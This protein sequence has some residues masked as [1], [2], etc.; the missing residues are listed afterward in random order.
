MIVALVG[1]SALVLTAGLALRGLLQDPLVAA[2]HAGGPS[3][4]RR[5]VRA[6]ASSS[7]P[8]TSAVAPA[9]LGAI[10]R[11]ADVLDR[12]RR[13]IAAEE[14]VARELACAGGWV[15]ER[16]VLVGTRRVPFVLLGPGGVFTLCATDGAWTLYDLEVLSRVGDELRDRLPG[17]RGRVEAVVC[18]AFDQAEP[19]AWYGGADSGR[20]RRL[21]AGRRPAAAVA[22]R[23]GATARPCPR[24]RRAGSRPRRDRTGGGG[25]H[26]AFRSA[27]ARADEPGTKPACHRA[28]RSSPTRC[29]RGAKFS[30]RRLSAVD[31]Q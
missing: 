5:R 26:R 14:R 15:V 4:A 1:A 13:L 24:R 27:G 10:D 18:L 20:T 31:A 2:P 17:Y 11:L 28:D 19:R 3:T 6:L 30:R 23:M 12:S 29:S 22:V 7:A 21:G 8:P 9:A 16:Y 25:R